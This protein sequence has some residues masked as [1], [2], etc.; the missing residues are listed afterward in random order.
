VT[1][2]LT[3]SLALATALCLLSAG[4]SSS[5]DASK[6]AAGKLSKEARLLSFALLA[7]DNAALGTDAAASID[8]SLV[9]ATL[10]AGTSLTALAPVVSISEKATVSPASGAAQNFSTPVTYTVTAEDGVTTRDY[11][12]VLTPRTDAEAPTPGADGEL[13]LVALGSTSAELSWVAASDDVTAPSALEYRVALALGD[14]IRSAEDVRVNGT[15]I[16]AWSAAASSATAVDLLPTVTYWLNVLVKD[17]AGHFAAYT[18]KSI[19]LPRDA[20]DS[21]DQEPP[22]PGAAGV[23]AISVVDA[24]T[25]RVEWTKATDNRTP[26]ADLT[27]RVY[28][29]ASNNLGSAAAALANGMSSA[30]WARDIGTLNVSS[31]ATGATY[32]FNVLVRD[33]AGGISAY[34]AKSAAL[35]FQAS[36]ALPPVPG[37][38]GVVTAAVPDVSSVDLA[39][40]EASDDVSAPATLE[41]RVMQSDSDNI[42]TVED[43]LANGEAAMAWTPDVTAVTV[44]PLSAGAEYWFT[45]LVRDGASRISAYAS[46]RVQLLDKVTDAQFVNLSHAGAS[47]AFSA[48]GSTLVVGAPGDAYNRG[49]AYVFEK[50]SGVFERRARL[51][52]SDGQVAALHGASVA[53]SA[54]GSTVVVGA[55]NHDC[56]GWSLNGL[57]YVYERPVSGWSDTTETT[58]SLDCV[59]PYYHGGTSVAVSADGGIAAVGMPGENGA[60]GLVAVLKRRTTTWA[61]SNYDRFNLTASDRAGGDYLGTS[62][63]I[64]ADGTTIIAGAPLADLGGPD[65]GAV[66]VF[67]QPGITWAS[68]TETKKLAQSGASDSD[69]LGTAVSISP[70]GATIAAG[71]TGRASST[72]MVFVFER[73]VTGWTAAAGTETTTLV[74]PTAAG[75]LTPHFGGALSFSADG[76]TLAVAAP[77]DTVEGRAYQGSVFIYGRSGSSYT[78]ASTLRELATGTESDRFGQSVS[79]TESGALLAV[80]CPNDDDGLV[81]DVGSTYLFSF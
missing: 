39:W 31:L 32:W 61:S 60:C 68:G 28:R 78:P 74:S 57:V 58:S 25:M 11:T 30:D 14:D 73:P 13:S 22:V 80:G 26:S 43:A 64:S 55:P 37:G 70:D 38:G 77:D 23:L 69:Q 48:D 56:G 49:Y 45:V 44:T 63:S 27:Y 54:D 5:S 17:A 2:E 9:G 8:G 47:V 21:C 10:P 19:R 34:A 7:K 35:V 53:V 29:S 42:Q 4:C 6:S 62:V 50:V 52:S 59:S 79:L 66:Y 1:Q 24:T 67:A 16:T 75:V 20:C 18:A 51:S 46:K 65:R 40:V 81:A 15:F 33:E 3:T 12:V 41:Y 72:G 76:S 36:D 71:A